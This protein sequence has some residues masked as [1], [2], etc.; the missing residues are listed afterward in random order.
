M[1]PIVYQSNDV[2]APTLNCTAGSL[3]TVLKAVLVNGFAARTPTSINR[4]GSTATVVLTG[5]GFAAYSNVEISGAGQT[6]YNIR[7]SITV[8][9][10]DR[11]TYQVSGTPATPATGTISVKLPGAGWTVA[12]DEGIIMQAVKQETR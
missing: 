10:A 7:T 6:E 4:S 8:V 2:G 3:I 5:H 9:D 12:L 11:F 1:L